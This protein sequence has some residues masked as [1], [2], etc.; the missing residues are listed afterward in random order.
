MFLW[1]NE[2]N[3]E[4]AEDSLSLHIMAPRILDTVR[5]GLSND[6]SF[7]QFY[8]F[9]I[10]KRSK[11]Y[12]TLKSFWLPGSYFKISNHLLYCD[13]GKVMQKESTPHAHTI[14]LSK[15]DYLL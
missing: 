10:T 13:L 9:T 12:H 1:Q 5:M 4:F 2:R 3:G 14:N 11:R 8:L 7:S 6:T 15:L